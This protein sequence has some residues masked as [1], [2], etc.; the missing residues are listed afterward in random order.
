M[1]GWADRID[2]AFRSAHERLGDSGEDLNCAFGNLCECAVSI[3]LPVR[4]TGYGRVG[5]YAVVS[6]AIAPFIVFGIAV[7]QWV[8]G[9]QRRSDQFR[10]PVG[11]NAD[12]GG[13]RTRTAA[14]VPARTMRPSDPQVGQL[15]GGPVR[16]EGCLRSPPTRSAGRSS[17][18][19]PCGQGAK[20]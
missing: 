12:D 16:P 13:R 2:R 6:A 1:W 17:R 5:S 9:E 10:E 11:D 15:G 18:R 8:V 20:P 14:T 7:T 4:L 19:I 3:G